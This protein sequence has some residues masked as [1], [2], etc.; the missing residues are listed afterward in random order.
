MGVQLVQVHAAHQ[1]PC[2]TVEKQAMPDPRGA[3]DRFVVRP[4]REGVRNDVNRDFD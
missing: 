1:S 2:P 4:V 3:N